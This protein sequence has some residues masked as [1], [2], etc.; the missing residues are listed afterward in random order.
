MLILVLVVLIILAL[1]VSSV[2]PLRSELS[3]FELKRRVEAGD[4]A[5]LILRRRNQLYLALRSLQYCLQ[6]TLLAIISA[7]AVSCLGWLWGLGLA[8]L[9]SVGLYRLSQL[10]H[11]LTQPQ[12]KKYEL[13][14]MNFVEDWG[15]II[16]A[17]G[18]PDTHR[19]AQRLGSRQE[20]RH[21]VEQNNSLFTTDEQLMLAGALNLDQQKVTEHMV[22][23]DLIKFVMA[24][25]L[26]G[27]LVLDDL[28]KTGHDYFPVLAGDLDN[29]VGLLHIQDLVSLKNKQSLKAREA[30]T[31]ALVYID[32]D[33]TMLAVL[34]MLA[35]SAAP[36]LIVRRDNQ[37]VG[38]IS[39]DDVTK[40]LFN[41]RR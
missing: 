16:K 12:Y 10:F 4:S 31:Q 9:I 29:I 13:S 6:A 41:S 18:L 40:L 11:F 20:L 1:L 15:I 19:P 22:G 38:L 5:A 30:A 7:L 36:L 23:R 21:I 26:I 8:V 24:E 25:D 39:L 37:T 34:K 27:P 3:S 14:L 28:H 17:I 32:H 33:A 35:T 2:R